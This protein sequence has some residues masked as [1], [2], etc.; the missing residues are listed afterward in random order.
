M[1][2][3]GFNLQKGELHFCLLNGNRKEP[4]YLAH[5]RHRFNPDQ[6]KPELANFFKLTFNELIDAH[7]AD[8]VAYRLS[9]DAKRADQLA[10]LVFPFGILNLIA[11]ERGIS[12]A[13]SILQ[14]YTKKALGFAGDKFDACDTLIANAPSPWGN[15]SKLAALSAWVAME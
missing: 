8:I 4:R 13:Q 10:Y 6:P 12:T 1:R 3:L 14:S 5:D 15:P 11:H 9:M 2:V 7:Q